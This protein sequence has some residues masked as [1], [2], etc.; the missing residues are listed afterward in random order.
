MSVRLEDVSTET[1]AAQD[2]IFADALSLGRAGGDVADREQAF[3]RLLPVLQIFAPSRDG[4]P[5]LH[6][7]HAST[8]GE[9][10]GRDFAL[11][12]V[13]RPGLAHEEFERAVQGAYKSVHLSG[14]PVSQRVSA[15][16]EVHGVRRLVSYY[17]L[18]F[19]INFGSN[20]VAGCLTR[21]SDAS[22]ATSLRTLSREQ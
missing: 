17:R 13:G 22:R 21:F 8:T 16:I 1:L 7:G 18:V 15:V 3:E 14:K 10:F 19:P 6:C 12:L 5:Y 9:L 2:A 20:R 11:D 4:A